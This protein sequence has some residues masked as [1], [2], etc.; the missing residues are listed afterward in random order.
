MIKT[1]IAAVAIAVM[2]ATASVAG[3]YSAP[4]EAVAPVAKPAAEGF[5]WTGAYAGI[6]IGK[7]GADLD[8]GDEASFDESATSYG[9][10]GGYRHQYTNRVVVGIEGNY[11]K[12]D[13]F[14]V[15][16]FAAIDGSETWGV[17][18][19]AGYAFDRILP[20]ASVGYARVAGEEGV[21]LGLG[22]DY[23]MTDN[24]IVGVKY[25]RTD[26]S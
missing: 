24:V 20:Y 8:F 1:T 19:Q 13:N 23:A 14:D 3:G 12:T 5:S 17:E 2:G 9:V 21:S 11:S 25:T 26:L 4:V 7:T 15:E 22:V 16:Q 10:F 18:A 6:A